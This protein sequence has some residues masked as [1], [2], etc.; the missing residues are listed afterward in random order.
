MARPTHGK[1]YRHLSLL[2]WSGWLLALCLGGEEVAKILPESLDEDGFNGHLGSNSLFWFFYCGFGAYQTTFVIQ[3]L[4]RR[5]AG[6][7]LVIT[8]IFSLGNRSDE[9]R[10]CSV[11]FCIPAFFRFVTNLIPAL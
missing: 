1:L 5:K 6:L 2:D 4:T 8:T 10:A 3:Y 9:V 11:F 7:I